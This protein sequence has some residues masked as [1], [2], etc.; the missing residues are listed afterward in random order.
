MA[1]NFTNLRKE[2]YIQIHEVQRVPKKMKPNRTTL[3]HIIAMAKMKEKFLN[4]AT[5]SYKGPPRIKPSA[6]LSTEMLQ[7]R[8]EW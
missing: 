8:K 4:T 5:V 3:R 2:T 1:E 6:D 7:A